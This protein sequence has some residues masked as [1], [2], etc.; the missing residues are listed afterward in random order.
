MPFDKGETIISYKSGVLKGFKNQNEIT[1]IN[2]F[3]QQNRKEK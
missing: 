3:I 1:L 2:Q